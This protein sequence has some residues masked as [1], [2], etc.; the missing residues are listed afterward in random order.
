[1]TSLRSAIRR[2]KAGSMLLAGL[3]LNRKSR[4]CKM[5]ARL[6]KIVPA[7]A[8]LLALMGCV[9][10]DGLIRMPGLLIPTQSGSTADARPAPAVC[11]EI[12]IVHY[13]VGKPAVTVA[14]IQAA[15]ALPESANPLGHA[16]N[17]LGDTVPTIAQV[18]DNN[19][20]LDRLCAAVPAK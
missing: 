5:R 18:Q 15:L 2:G 14:D 9:S 16:R 8:M 3:R 11:S 17:L 12:T 13:S 10:S 6:D 19:A 1:M 7:L 4:S 20:V